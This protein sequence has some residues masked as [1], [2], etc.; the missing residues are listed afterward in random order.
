MHTYPYSQVL[1]IKYKCSSS[2]DV[3]SHKP[4]SKWL[5][6]PIC[7]WSGIATTVR[8]DRSK[9]VYDVG[10]FQPQIRRLYTLHEDKA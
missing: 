2:M 3:S 8:A 9:N 10:H 1:D 4:M 5:L 7:L 6:S